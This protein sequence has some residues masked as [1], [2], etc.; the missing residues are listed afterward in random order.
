[1]PM[2]APPMESITTFA[3]VPTVLSGKNRYRI[4]GLFRPFRDLGI[5]ALSALHGSSERY[6]GDDTLAFLEQ[7]GQFILG[8]ASSELATQKYF[9]K[10]DHAYQYKPGDKTSLELGS[11]VLSGNY[12]LSRAVVEYAVEYD[13]GHRQPVSAVNIKLDIDDHP[14]WCSEYGRLSAS[15][16]GRVH[17]LRVAV[18]NIAHT[19]IPVPDDG[20]TFAQLTLLGEK[21]VGVQ[22]QKV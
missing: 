13:G 1:M 21:L 5:L 19:G 14:R 18:G 8:G 4:S 10:G 2:H 7:V 11:S 15:S 12:P 9:A 6:V 22:G 20:S 17:T 3:A 16:T